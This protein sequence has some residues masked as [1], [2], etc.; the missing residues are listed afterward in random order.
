[1]LYLSLR[2]FVNVCVIFENVVLLCN[3]SEPLL[4]LTGDPQL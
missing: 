3:I 2:Y 4:I 1:M